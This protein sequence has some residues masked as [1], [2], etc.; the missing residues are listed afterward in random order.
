[1]LPVGKYVARAVQAE[2]GFADTGTELVAVQFEITDGEHKGTRIAWRGYFTDKTSR[3][4]VESLKY[5]GWKGDWDHWDGLGTLDVQLDVQE[6]RDMKTGEIRG[7]RVA[8]VNPVRVPMKNSMDQSQRSQFAAKMKGLVTEILTTPNGMVSGRGT[9]PFRA[10]KA[11]VP[12]GRQA[13]A[14]L[15]WSS[16]GN[17][18]RTEGNVA[19]SKDE[20]PAFEG[21]DIPF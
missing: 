16:G 20:E 21:D 2:L 14:T 1:M 3:R 17:A 13:G 12:N 6:D 8:W 11:A 7:T 19:Y 9:L 4:V 18:G 10:A 5:T 15:V